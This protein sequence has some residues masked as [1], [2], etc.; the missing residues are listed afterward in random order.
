MTWCWERKTRNDRVQDED[1]SFKQTAI[2]R[3]FGQSVH[4]PS[5]VQLI[6]VELVKSVL[7]LRQ[8]HKF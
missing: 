4:C 6:I 1:G 3:H 7:T 5:L 2:L 8:Q